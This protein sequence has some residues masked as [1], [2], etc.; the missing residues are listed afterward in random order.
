MT[1]FQIS[2]TV[3]GR[4]SWGCQ[5]AK[6]M[7]RATIYLFFPNQ[8]RQRFREKLQSLNRQHASH[9]NPKTIPTLNGLFLLIFL[10][11][12]ALS[13]TCESSESST[14]A[15]L[16]LTFFAGAFFFFDPAVVEVAFLVVLVL[17]EFNSACSLAANL[18]SSSIKS[19]F[20]FLFLGTGAVAGD[21]VP[22]GEL[23][24]SVAGVGCP[25]CSASARILSKRF[26]IRA[27]RL[28][29]RELVECRWLGTRWVP[30]RAECR[31]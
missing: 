11:F 21:A 31:R 10:F 22:F 8:S 24:L 26:A 15:L 14:L 3:D 4:E 6:I 25:F 16:F 2:L 9:P 1:Y 19:L 5:L 20:F 13:S 23:L 28:C 27:E 7:S 29:W 30:C 17:V 18:A 12:F